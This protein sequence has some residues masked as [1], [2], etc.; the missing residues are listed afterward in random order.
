MSDTQAFMAV[1]HFLSHNVRTKYRAMQSGSRTSGLT[2]WPEG[3]Q[4][5]L[6]TDATPAVIRNATNELRSVRQSADED[7][8][9]YWARINHEAY[10]CGNIHEEEEK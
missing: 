8:L 10:R 9:A 7:E 1:P 4:Y 2:F 6:R 3:V 5:P